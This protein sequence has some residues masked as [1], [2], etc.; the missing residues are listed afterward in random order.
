M[1]VEPRRSGPLEVALV[2]G[3]LLLVNVALWFG[4]NMSRSVSSSESPD[5]LRTVASKLAS[6]GVKGEAAR[7]YARYLEQADISDA[8]RAQVGLVLARLLKED[9]RL[10]ESLGYLYRVE[11]WAPGSEAA[12]DAAPLI[13]EV[14]ERL[15]LG[16]AAQTALSSRSRLD[17][18]PASPPAEG[19]VVAKIGNE[20]LTT[21]D[22]DR[23]LEGL[24][25]PLQEQLKD[26]E[27]RKQFL[28]QFVAQELLY[29]KAVKRSLDK[30]PEVRRQ[31]DAISRQV[32]T[33]RLLEEELKD[34]VRADAG[35]LRN[36]YQAHADEFKGADGK[37]APFEQVQDR[38]KQAYM[39]SKLQSLSQELLA[40]AQ[41]A[42]EVQ[43]FP[44][45]LDGKSASAGGSK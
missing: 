16:Q 6:V 9:G 34:K 36:F 2:G 41:A 11:Q 4:L 5:P 15:G 23:A 13:V 7:Y 10:E 24:P 44:E 40:Q 43:L 37:P 39:M 31:I 17:Q 1:S 26:P 22:L 30:D 14:L 35:D 33:S 12:K 8:N 20:P 32:I 45:A 29:R 25:P 3:L 27:K 21:G 28:P 38:V 18:S 42:Q 19:A